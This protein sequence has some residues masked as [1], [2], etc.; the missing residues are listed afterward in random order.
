[1]RN[2]H[3]PLRLILSSGC[4][5]ASAHLPL[6]PRLT[7][8]GLGSKKRPCGRVDFPL[9]PCCWP[10][11]RPASSHFPVPASLLSP[12]L[13]RFSHLAATQRQESGTPPP[14]P[15][16]CCRRSCEKE[17]RKKESSRV[18]EVCVVQGSAQNTYTH[19]TARSPYDG[20]GCMAPKEQTALRSLISQRSL[21]TL[22]CAMVL[23]LLISMHPY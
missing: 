17:Q 13:V 22:A 11:A 20:G 9:R 18:V 3:R 15:P 4:P 5:S 8:I 7:Q 23:Q 6:I 14:P 10:G 21:S 16:P 2:W 19:M 1:M 12:S